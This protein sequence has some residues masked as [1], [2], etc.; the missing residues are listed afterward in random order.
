MSPLKAT[1]QHETG[2]FRRAQPARWV[3]PRPSSLEGDEP[4][5][6]S[7]AEVDL[8]DRLE[9]ALVDVAV[10]PHGLD[11]SEGARERGTGVDG[12]RPTP[13]WVRTTTPDTT[14]EPA[15]D[16]VRRE[17]VAS[18]PN[19]TWVADIT[20][21][22]TYEGWLFLG[23]VMDLYSRKIVGWSLRD[24]LEGPLVVDAISAIARR[25]PKPG[26]EFNR[27]SRPPASAPA[28]RVSWNT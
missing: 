6:G 15:P 8:P 26:L 24:D 7:D 27:S 19:E 18:K 9:P 2:R 11:V 1:R 13:G 10:V 22:P 28:Y 21:V 4:E 3:R 5:L 14:A 20:Y 12:A 17:F 16:L 23:A 25:K